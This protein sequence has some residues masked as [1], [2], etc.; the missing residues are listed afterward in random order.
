MT[1]VPPINEHITFPGNI[2]DGINKEAPVNKTKKTNRI[3]V[4]FTY[5]RLLAVM[6]CIRWSSLHVCIASQDLINILVRLSN[7]N[8]LGSPGF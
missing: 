5:I 7:P 2:G 3:I 4:P 6:T 8:T 1:A